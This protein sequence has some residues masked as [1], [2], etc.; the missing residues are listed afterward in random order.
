MI[1]QDLLVASHDRYQKQDGSTYIRDKATLEYSEE[2][3]GD[4]ERLSSG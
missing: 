3:T 2:G 4:E 1:W